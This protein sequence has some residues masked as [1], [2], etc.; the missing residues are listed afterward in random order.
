MNKPILTLLSLISISATS[1]LQAA[2]TPEKSPFMR[3]SVNWQPN[4]TDIQNAKKAW[5]TLHAWQKDK[6]ATSRKL[7]VV[8]VTFRDR[9]ALP[10]YRERYDH[11]LKNIQ[12]YYA[13]QM[14]A[15]GYP[16]LTFQLDLD[17]RGKL[18]IHDAHVDKPMSEMTV[19]NSGGISREAAKKVLASKGIDIDKEHTLIVCQLPDGVGPYYGGGFS[20]QG[21]GWTCDIDGLDPANF[22]DLS[23]QPNARYGGSRGR[24]AT[25]YIGGTAHELGHAFG[26]PH[27]GNGW[28][29][30]NAGR[31]LMGNGNHTYGQELRKEGAGTFLSPTDAMKLASV[32]LFSGV[33]FPFPQ[34]ARPGRW[35]GRYVAGNF[36]E[37]KA[38]SLPDGLTLKGKVQMTRPAYGLVV[39]LDPPGNSDYDTNAVCTALNPD[40]SFEVTIRR[41][42]FRQG[43][44]E[45]RIAVLNCDSTRYML[46]VPVNCTSKGYQVPLLE[47]TICFSSVKSLWSAGKNEL[48]LQKLQELEARND[49]AP[50]TKALIPAMKKAIQPGN[51]PVQKAASLPESVKKI[52]L[53]DVKAE[54]VKVGYAIPY[55]N[56]VCPCD[57]GPVPC[58]K[59]S[60]YANNFIVAHAPA[61]L[62][63]HLDGKWKQF[64]ADVGMPIGASGSVAFE[65]VA[66]GVCVAKSPVMMDGESYP[67]SVDISGAKTLEIR[68]TDGG[69]GN[70]SDWSVVANGELSR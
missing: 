39:H 47:P 13:D 67:L 60:G 35:C 48:A 63:Y 56:T 3:L 64:K 55:W 62:V 20:H 33:E 38:I 53:S 37:L 5:A 1:V 6:P 50:E 31:S 21:S 23:P 66:D 58:F 49:L 32:P 4:K 16:P 68:I 2:E 40:G 65:V 69:N 51:P 44:L 61:S 25:V 15:I 22:N 26:L 52:A 18:I 19:R 24:N 36:E 10:N 29:Y 45:M 42:D 17:E 11:I 28:D 41:P 30:P 27:T 46:T 57:F 7:H 43:S 9:P 8:Y 70:G 14:Q 54:S 34:D 59:N 12:A